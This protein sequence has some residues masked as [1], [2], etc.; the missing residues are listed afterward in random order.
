VTANNLGITEFFM[1]LRRALR[2]EVNLN[3]PSVVSFPMVDAE[4]ALWWGEIRT[5]DLRMRAIRDEFPP[6]SQTTD[7]FVEYR[8]MLEGLA[9]HAY[10]AGRCRVTPDGRRVVVVEL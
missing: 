2:D 10:E 7:L 5:H 4:G 9:S 1:S 8:E 6:G 3:N